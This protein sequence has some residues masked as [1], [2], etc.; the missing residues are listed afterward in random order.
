MTLTDE[1]VPAGEYQPVIAPIVVSSSR[2]ELRVEA[3]QG[4]REDTPHYDIRFW[5][6]G[7]MEIPTRSGIRLSQSET[8]LLRDVLNTLNLNACEE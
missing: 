1:F 3:N 8:R 2:R 6:A 4:K 7:D 5:I